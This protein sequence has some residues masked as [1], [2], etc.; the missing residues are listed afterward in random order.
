MEADQPSTVPAST[1]RGDEVARFD[2]LAATWWN[3]EGPMRPLHVI[4]ALR[5]G[6]VL[7]Q[8]A[9]CFGRPVGDL[10]GLRIAGIGCS[11]G[12]MCEPLAARGAHVVGVDAAAKNIAAARLHASAGRERIEGLNNAGRS[13]AAVAIASDQSH[14]HEAGCSNMGQGDHHRQ[15]V[16]PLEVPS[17]PTVG[18]AIDGGHQR[19]PGRHRGDRH[20]GHERA[21]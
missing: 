17:L 5:L 9:R 8:I 16:E 6:Y 14:K 2:R 18:R 21:R 13:I 10:H 20:H 7:E 15:P 19:L 1:I 4:H 12:L 11:A 3:S